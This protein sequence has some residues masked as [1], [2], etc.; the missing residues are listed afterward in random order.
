[1]QFQQRAEIYK[2]FRSRLTFLKIKIVSFITFFPICQVRKKKKD[3]LLYIRIL[4][5][6]LKKRSR[7]SRKKLK[8]RLNAILR[9]KKKYCFLY[10]IRENFQKYNQINIVRS[11]YLRE[12]QNIVIIIS[13]NRFRL[14]S[15]RRS[16]KYNTL[17]KKFGKSYS[18]FWF[19]AVVLCVLSLKMDFSTLNYNK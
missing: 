8:E 12:K 15:H 9:V 11:S 4:Q 18:L 19:E 5:P 10:I 2:I 7:T 6:S 3:F 14:S 17:S 13:N 1:M 16:N